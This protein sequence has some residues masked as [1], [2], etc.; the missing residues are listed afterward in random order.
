MDNMV[1]TDKNGNK[2]EANFL[3]AH[4]DEKF[5]KNYVIYQNMKAALLTD[6][7]YI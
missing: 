5:K 4:Y 3:F 2:I 7:Y 1:L 6:R